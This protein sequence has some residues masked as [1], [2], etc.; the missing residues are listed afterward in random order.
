MHGASQ[1]TV[2]KSFL[3][4]V[5]PNNNQT[6]TNTNTFR[7]VANLSIGINIPNSMLLRCVDN[8]SRHSNPNKQHGMPLMAKVNVI[9]MM[10]RG[11][12]QRFDVHLGGGPLQRFS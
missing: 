2:R 5:I 4:L 6:A 12:R 3:I 10:R 1:P 8:F 7:I 9:F 11:R